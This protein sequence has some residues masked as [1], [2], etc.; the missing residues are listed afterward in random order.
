MP[1]ILK[2]GPTWTFVSDFAHASATYS[3][4]R[5]ASGQGAS[6]YVDGAILYDGVT[7]ARVSYNGKVWAPEPWKSGAIPIFNPYA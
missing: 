3:A 1:L 6:T 7:V 4:L 5:D 2:I